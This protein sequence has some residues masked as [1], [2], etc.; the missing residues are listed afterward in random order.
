MPCRT[1]TLQAPAG[2]GLLK[3]NAWGKHR[4]RCEKNPWSMKNII[5]KCWSFHIN[6]SLPLDM[7]WYVLVSKGNPVTYT[8]PTYP[9]GDGWNPCSCWGPIGPRWYFSVFHI[10][11]IGWSGCQRD[12]NHAHPTLVVRWC[13]RTQ[14]PRQWATCHGFCAIVLVIDYLVTWPFG[15]FGQDFRSNDVHFPASNGSAEWW[16]LMKPR[17]IMSCGNVF[18]FLLTIPLSMC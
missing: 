9:F 1:L 5:F 11:G 12:D 7:W 15:I 14:K 18:F 3:A 16:A 13:E 2:H 6:L 4:K 10:D 17:L 8:Y